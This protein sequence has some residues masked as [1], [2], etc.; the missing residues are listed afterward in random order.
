L[1][2]GKSIPVNCFLQDNLYDPASDRWTGTHLQNYMVARALMNAGLRVC[3]IVANSTGSEFPVPELYRSIDVHQLMVNRRAPLLDGWRSTLSLLRRIRPDYV[4][5]RGR[6]WMTGVAGSYARSEGAVSMWASN[7]EDGCERWKFS[8]K[9]LGSR[10]GLHRVALKLLFGAIEDLLY[11]RG[12][13]KA[14]LA[15]NQTS[16][17]QASLKKEFGRDGIVIHSIQDVPDGPFIKEQPPVV[18]WVGQVVS[19]KRPELFLRLAEHCADLGATFRM[20]GRF[21]ESSGLKNDLERLAS[22]E[23]FE[24]LGARGRDEVLDQMSRASLIVNTS[25]PGG[26]GIPNAMVEAWMRQVPVLSF[27]LDPSGLVSRNDAGIVC[28]GDFGKF[29]DACRKLL[30]DADMLAEMGRRAR[31]TALREFSAEGNSVHYLA[32]IGSVRRGGEK[33]TLSEVPEPHGA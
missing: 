8:K 7:G 14:D 18:L 16:T 25:T 21:S 30:G 12:I 5:S 11:A 13:A 32:A 24:Y 10:R 19:E 3:F 27:E 29:H 4:Y 33:K 15:I 22:H 31:E 20:I 2:N 17:Q 9:A 6:T 23:G 1:N 28:D 26:D